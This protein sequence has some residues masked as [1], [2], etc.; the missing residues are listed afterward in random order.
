[1]VIPPVRTSQLIT[2]VSG[3]QANDHAVVP[4]KVGAGTATTA[5]GGASTDVP[6]AGSLS[7]KLLVGVGVAVSAL[8]PVQ[9]QAQAG[10]TS[11]F[12]LQLSHTMT[13]DSTASATSAAAKDTQV[14]VDSTFTQ[15]MRF[16]GA[17]S[18]TVSLPKFD[19][20]AVASARATP[21]L[22]AGLISAN[23]KD[24]AV[25]LSPMTLAS[26]TDS[27]SVAAPWRMLGDVVLTARR[28]TNSAALEALMQHASSMK[29]TARQQL[30]AVLQLALGRAV[31]ASES[32][33]PRTLELPTTEVAQ[34]S[35]L[36]GGA[37]VD[38]GHT[39]SGIVSAALASPAGTLVRVGPPGPGEALL[40]LHLG[41]GKLFVPGEGV[42]ADGAARLT[43]AATAVGTQ[44]LSTYSYTPA[45]LALWLNG[46]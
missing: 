25:L 26:S 34:S 1:M 33:S 2:S 22:L 40:G 14:P 17:D 30:S 35:M 46:I 21:T 32:T 20:V 38:D 29:L 7:K 4:S 12:Q 9:A 43:T 45:S 5:A 18:A 13:P 6:D 15:V 39:V 37:P 36:K 27:V 31:G 24:A 8:M 10:S 16:A 11:R 28:T 23:V 19:S 44:V 42:V 41:E 3:T